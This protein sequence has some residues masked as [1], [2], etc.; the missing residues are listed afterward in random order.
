M[1]LFKY[2]PVTLLLIIMWAYDT[3]CSGNESYSITVDWVR[4]IPQADT[5]NSSYKGLFIVNDTLIC[6]AGYHN[7]T[8]GF[9]SF[10]FNGGGEVETLVELPPYWLWAQEVAPGQ[11]Y[12]GC[13]FMCSSDAE[14]SV[15]VVSSGK[16]GALIMEN[17]YDYSPNKPYGHALYSTENGGYAFCGDLVH[18]DDNPAGR[19]AFVGICDSTGHLLW[20]TTLGNQ[21]SNF[22]Y[23]IIEI[24]NGNLLVSSR[25]WFYLQDTTV[26]HNGR[27]VFSLD[28][29]SPEGIHIRSI[30][31]DISTAIGHPEYN[32]ILED[33]IGNIFLCGTLDRVV[34]VRKFTPEGDSLWHVL[35]GNRGNDICP[36]SV[37]FR[38]SLL[39]VGN[40]LLDSEVAGEKR[41]IYIRLFNGNGDSLATKFITELESWEHRIQDLLCINDTTC[42]ATG[43]IRV[44]SFIMRLTIKSDSE[45][46]IRPSVVSTSAR[47]KNNCC[48]D[49]AGRKIPQ[50]TIL[51]RKHYRHRPSVRLSEQ[52]IVP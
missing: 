8:Q 37:F 17:Y 10:E 23:D 13:F 28:W 42:F 43:D 29:F 16:N 24:R 6:S 21:G 27:W 51:S 49:I 5:S 11:D 40:Y 12:N 14:D 15:L 41:G 2:S 36:T 50:S 35:L 44:R 3:P 32:T 52:V 46:G 38:D 30:K 7:A 33:S 9:F 31:G 26:S 20:D 19:T 25:Q 34:S 48:Y 45:T 22:G 47:I 4:Y 1:K 39:L 18:N